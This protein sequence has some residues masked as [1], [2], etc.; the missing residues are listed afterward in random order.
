MAHTPAQRQAAKRHAREHAFAAELCEAAEDRVWHRRR[1]KQY[2]AVAESRGTEGPRDQGT[3]GPSP[4]KR[5]ESG[6]VKCDAK[7]ERSVTTAPATGAGTVR[8]R[9]R[10]DATV[11]SQRGDSTVNEQTEPSAS[12][13]QGARSP[14]RVFSPHQQ[15][16]ISNQTSPASS[17]CRVPRRALSAPGVGAFSMMALAAFGGLLA[18]GLWPEASVIGVQL[19]PLMLGLAANVGKDDLPFSPFVKPS[20]ELPLEQ[21]AFITPL[22][23]ELVGKRTWLVL[24]RL[25]FVSQSG[26]Q[27]VVNPAFRTDFASIPW[28]LRSVLAR[29]SRTARAAVFHDFWVRNIDYSHA[30]SYLKARLQRDRWFRVLLQAD[31]VQPY[32]IPIY[33]RGVNLGTVWATLV[34]CLRKGRLMR[35]LR[36]LSMLSVCAMIGAMCLLAAGCSVNVH[37]DVQNNMFPASVEQPS[38]QSAQSALAFTDSDGTA[39]AKAK[40]YHAT[41]VAPYTQESDTQADLEQRLSQ[42]FEA[43]VSATGQGTAESSAERENSST[44]EDGAPGG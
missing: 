12:D 39:D 36:S 3:E 1:A 40:G 8:E 41:I 29:Q 19:M 9:K 43:A 2:L 31:Y 14:E 23:V 6:R 7:R 5:G 22:R 44:S 4:R 26:V 42:A 33:H 37:K 32:L 27:Y 15:S 28:F 18:F 34:L 35:K 20:G 30:L 16:A 11:D 38:G 24:E 25:V 13:A 17:P 10:S 21:A